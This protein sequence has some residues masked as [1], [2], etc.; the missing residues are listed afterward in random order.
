MEKNA[1]TLRQPF[2]QPPV[3]VTLQGVRFDGR[4]LLYRLITFGT[5]LL[6]W[7][8][9]ARHYN[10]QL[11]LPTPWKT[12]GALVFAVQDPETLKNLA[13]TLK[14]V[15]VGLGIALAIGLP[16]GLA[17]GYSQL[18]H[19][20][21][22]PIIGPLRQV[23]IMAWVPLTIVWFGLG[24]GPTLFL[25][26]MVA[27][28]PIMISTMAGVQGVPQSY[29][30]AARSMGAGPM[31]VFTRITLPGALPEIITGLRI[32]LSSGWMSVI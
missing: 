7:H 24:E 22:D 16:V 11:V 3:R 28:F 27:T 4:K 13:L 20:L 31:A 19:K 25:I 5:L 2:R 23:P 8:L 14:R 12:A 10:N 32:G 29:Y 26:A 30:H 1:G 17:M 21:V 9:A 6:I 15:M 18:A